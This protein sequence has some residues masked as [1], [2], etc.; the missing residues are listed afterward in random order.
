MLVDAALGMAVQTTAP[1]GTA[2]ASLDL[3]VNLLRPAA[4]DGRDLIARATV[5]HRGRTLAV[6]HGEVT[7][8][9]GRRVAL[10]TSTVTILEGRTATLSYPVVQ[11]DEALT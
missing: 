2:I 5:A 4:P 10:A 9:D 8:A 6:A 11:E 1:A 7:D 3:K